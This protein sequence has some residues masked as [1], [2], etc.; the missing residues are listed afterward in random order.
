VRKSGGGKA[1]APA[2]GA[3]ERSALAQQRVLLV[4]VI[5]ILQILRNPSVSPGEEA[6]AAEGVVARPDGDA[7]K[8]G[9]TSVERIGLSSIGTGFAPV[10]QELTET[11]PRVPPKAKAKPNDPPPGPNLGEPQNSKV[12]SDFEAVFV[13]A[14]LPDDDDDEGISFEELLA[15]EKARGPLYVKASLGHNEPVR[16]SS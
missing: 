3:A 2:H 1:D 10:K 7:D 6:G 13:D 14:P 9:G 16:G 15:Q 11:R 8:G 5:S 12:M 4:I